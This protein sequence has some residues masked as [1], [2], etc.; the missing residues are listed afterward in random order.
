MSVWRLQSQRTSLCQN[1]SPAPTSLSV[2]PLYW[3]LAI[4]WNKSKFEIMLSTL[5]LLKPLWAQWFLLFSWIASSHAFLP[6]TSQLL[7]SWPVV[8]PNLWNSDRAPPYQLTVSKLHSGM[9]CPLFGSQLVLPS[10]K[11]RESMSMTSL[12]NPACVLWTLFSRYLQSTQS[13]TSSHRHQWC[14]SPQ[15]T[16]L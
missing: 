8:G 13:S 2:S 3:N 1:L 16:R 7:R 11:W 6:P 9:S 15:W 5:Y 10:L 14:S 12:V 4:N